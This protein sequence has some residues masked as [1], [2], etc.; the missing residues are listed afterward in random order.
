[1]FFGM[2][3]LTHWN[4]KSLGFYSLLQDDEIVE[5]VYRRPFTS[6]FVKI[7]FFF[8]LYGGIAL[9]LWFVFRGTHFWGVWNVAAIFTFYKILHMY[10]QWYFN[11]ILMTTNN[12]IF[13]AWEGLF[14]KNY[15]RL[16]YW[17]LD[18]VQVMRMGVK[19]F[20]SNY[21]DL[22]FM[23]AGAGKLHNFKKINRPNKVAREIEAYREKQV[24]SKNFTEESALKELL[25][26]MVQTHVKGNGQPERFSKNEVPNSKPKMQEIKITQKFKPDT[27][28][29]EVEKKLDDE[30]GIEL[31]LKGK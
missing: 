7:L 17:N 9:G 29:I 4:W 22:Y 1:M 19:S 16:D 24:D 20:L 5:K 21:G 2:Q 14:Q 10:S 6:Y 3:R 15:T 23:K 11:A 13:V 18:E 31:D 25:S 12:L 26:N 8:V 27:T 30:G 28:P